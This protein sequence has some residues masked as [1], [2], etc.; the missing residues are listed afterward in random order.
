M[1]TEVYY[2]ALGLMSGTSLD[3][4]DLAILTTDGENYLNTGAYM[5]IAYEESLRKELR[6]VL[7]NV[8]L[9]S[10]ETLRDRT[11]WP[12][13]LLKAELDVT[14]AHLNAVRMF[15]KGE[16]A[17]EG[18][19]LIGFHGQTVCYRPK[20]GFTLQIGNGDVLAQGHQSISA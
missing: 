15:L 8:Q 14:N 20:E 3:G 18:V 1:A 5:T 4:I 9:L 7:V 16:N 10:T 19:S 12:E 2:T 11:I 6:Q 13:Y 17:K